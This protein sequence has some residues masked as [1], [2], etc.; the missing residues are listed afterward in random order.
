MPLEVRQ[1]SGEPAHT[2]TPALG[3]GKV[4]TTTGFASAS[5]ARSSRLVVDQGVPDDARL[6]APLI[7]R[8]NRSAPGDL[9]ASEIIAVRDRV[10]ERPFLA[11]LNLSDGVFIAGAIING[12]VGVADRTACRPYRL[13]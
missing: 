9:N 11:L 1:T 7:M 6:A 4:S 13:F 3:G 10:T 2:R 12:Q 8:T 5:K